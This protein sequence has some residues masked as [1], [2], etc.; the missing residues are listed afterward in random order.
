MQTNEN[1]RADFVETVLPWIVTIAAMVLYL[2]TLN[3]WVTVA[4]LPVVAKVTHWDWWSLSLQSPLFYVVT[5]PVRWLPGAWQPIALNVL[6]ALFAACTLGLL[7]RSVALLPHDRT[8]DQRQRER[9]EYSLL[10]IPSAWVP[11]VLAVLACGLQLTFWENATAAT[12]ESL[13]VLMFAYV[14]RCLLGYRLD[15]QDSWLYRMAFVYGLAVTNNW[16]M[17]AFFPPLLAALLWIQGLRF[18]RLSFLLRMVGIG[19]L[20]LLLYIYLPLVES[21]G[22]GSSTT[23]WELLKTELSMQRQ[24]VLS[25]PKYVVLLCALTSLLP[26][27]IMG[28]RWPSSF[29][30]TSV[31]G[32]MM[33]NVM[34]HVVHVLFLVVCLW[35][36][37]DPPF[38][39]RVLG[40]GY[41]FLPLYYLSA[42]SIGY[43]SGYFLLV[44]GTE[45]EKRRHH[46]SEASRLGG[47]LLAGLVWVALLAVPVGLVYHNWPSMQAN[48]GPYLKRLAND[49]VRGLP[50]RGA[51]VMSDEPLDLLLVEAVLDHSGGAN[52]HLLLDTR[53]LPYHE[54]QR[55]VTKRDP[56]KWPDFLTGSSVP[57]PIDSLTLLRRMLAVARTNAIFYLHPSYGFYAEGLSAEP[58]GLVYRMTPYLP[59]IVTNTPPTPATVATNQAFWAKVNADFGT[60]P[61]PAAKT[62]REA[63]LADLEFVRRFYS[64]AAN[65]WGVE[66]Q[67]AGHLPEASQNFELALRLNPDNLVAKVNQDYNSNLRQG[68][69]RPV[70]LTL[71][72]D[73]K[74]KEKYRTWEDRLYD[75]GP[76]DEPKFCAQMGE[77][78]ALA[79][80][81]LIRLGAQQCIRAVTLN[82]GNLDAQV[83]LANL[84]LKWPLA[85]NTL[86]VVQAMEAHQDRYPLGLPYQ[87]ELVRL[88]AWAYLSLTNLDQAV[89]VLD[90]AQQ[91]NPGVANFSQTKFEVFLKSSQVS[92]PVLAANRL[93][94]ALAAVEQQLRLDPDNVAALCNKGAVCLQ[95]K[96][97]ALAITTLSQALVADPKN[98]AAR[99]D[100]ALAYVQGGQWDLA[101]N[102]Y[103]ELRKLLP[104]EKVYKVYYGLGEIAFQQKE[105]SKA[106]TNYELY[107]KDAPRD[108]KDNYLD[109]S[110]AELAPRVKE[111]V[112][113]LKGS[114]A[115][116]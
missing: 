27:L 92:D 86:A 15:S 54:Y 26:V 113:Q 70:E 94:N 73:T 84:Y 90:D 109:P 14:I 64:R 10:S 16:A 4:S 61:N 59:G 85:S 103:E 57:E 77:N 18:F 34:F 51:I 7:A 72:F 91:K 25:F 98:I 19:A 23:F 81:P 45:P 29:G 115:G 24:A 46:V 42:L 32:A 11:P 50:S 38:S 102:D 31:I 106:I 65:C 30:D 89:K 35:V 101:K 1:T 63:T 112:K 22:A 56:A 53:S 67:K 12:G 95:L 62:G 107:L 104:A 28:I 58:L 20:G 71:E 33:T 55:L 39:P 116:G 100:R 13:N 40:F 43:F 37:F 21:A 47:R 99:M 114:G 82:P 49:M 83:W 36:V 66:L 110:D 48:N 60:L 80:P 68:Q 93:S 17:I 88:K 44:F 108:K 75:N 9:S 96:Q 8:R 105:T 69:T 74:I 6:S 111:R 2:A 97:Y 5:S 78:F 41:R 79:R 3:H 76:F 87:I 52:N